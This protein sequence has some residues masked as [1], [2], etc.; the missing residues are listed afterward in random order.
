MLLL[1]PTET[2]GF[3]LAHTAKQYF[4]TVANPNRIVL[5]DILPEWNDGD[6]LVDDGPQKITMREVRRGIAASPA[7]INQALYDAHAVEID[8][9]DVKL[10]WLMKGYVYRMSPAYVS[11][12]LDLI[13][14]TSTADSLPL[15]N[16]LVNEILRSLSSEDEKPE[17]IHAILKSFSEVPRERTYPFLTNLTRA[18]ALSQE[19]VTRWYG[20]RTLSNIT[21]GIQQTTAFL[22]DWTSSLPIG[23]DKVKPNLNLLRGNYHHPTPTQ[24]QYLPASGLSKNPE[25]RF[26]QLFG[27]KDR[28]VMDEIMPFL[29]GCVDGGEGWEKKAERECH[30]W[31]RVRGGMVMDKHS[32]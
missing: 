17:C 24:I 7:E 23:I 30:K 28:W 4:E 3:H 25:D 22:S 26:A 32:Y 10:R 15:N 5:D 18:Y 8:G 31:A 1:S 9:I 29:E 2:D 20:L 14:I 13:I 21:G 27:I 6:M 12:L 19:K 11:Q 16:L